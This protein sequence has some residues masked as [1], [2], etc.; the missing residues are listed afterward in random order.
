MDKTIKDFTVEDWVSGVKTNTLLR[1]EIIPEAPSPKEQKSLPEAIIQLK[2]L[3]YQYFELLEQNKSLEEQLYNAQC[4]IRALQASSI[5]TTQE[6]PKEA[7]LGTHFKDYRKTILKKTSEDLETQSLSSQIYFQNLIIEDLMCKLQNMHQKVEY[8]KEDVSEL[9]VQYE[10]EKSFVE[11]E[12]RNKYEVDGKHHQA[13]T[14]IKRLEAEIQRVRTEL[15]EAIE[16]KEVQVKVIEVKS[17][18]QI[19]AENMMLQN[20]M[21]NQVSSLR[22]KYYNDLLDIQK[23]NQTA[24]ENLGLCMKKRIDDLKNFY[25]YRI[26]SMINEFAFEEAK[27]YSKIQALKQEI[28]DH[29]EKSHEFDVNL[30]IRD[31]TISMKSK[32]ISKAENTIKNLKKLLERMSFGYIEQKSKSQSMIEGLIKHSQEVENDLK[33][34]FEHQMK[35]A[36]K[37]HEEAMKGLKNHYQMKI[38]KINQEFQISEKKIM[39]RDKKQYNVLLDEIA[40][41]EKDKTEI[42]METESRVQDVLREAKAVTYK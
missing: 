41:I 7:S 6:D 17:D 22:T 30:S 11:E 3:E 19:D 38:D 2:K 9:K 35:I 14:T 13:Q 25:E 24:V 39:E 15:K 21:D 31:K 27:F 34:D 40:K 23:K 33:R 12:K 5:I 16:R 36:E 26:S 37:N 18:Y 42:E 20:K 28:T 4:Q 10:R 29:F 32:N 1:V 8:Y